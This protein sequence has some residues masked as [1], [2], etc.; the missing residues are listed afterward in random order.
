MKR[1][2]AWAA[3]FAFS[4][5]VSIGAAPLPIKG[6]DTLELVT[7]DAIALCSLGTL[8][9]YVGGGSGTGQA[10]MVAGTQQVAPMSREL[11]GTACTASASQLLIGLDG[12]SI[13]TSNQFFG[14][15]I[16]QTVETDDNCS[17][18]I[19]GDNSLTVAGCT[20]ADGCNTP[21]TY[22]FTDWKDVMAMVYGG[23]NHT[24][25]VQ[26]INGARNPARINCASPVRQALVNNWNAVFRDSILDPQPCRATDCLRLKHAFRRGDQSGTTDTF[27]TLV[28]LVAIPPYTTTTANNLPIPDANAT[29]NPFCNAGDNKMNKGDAD[30]LDLD[31]IR[32]IVDSDM[33]ANGRLGFEQVAQGFQPPS[34][35]PVTQF[36]D[37]RVEPPVTVMADYSS[38]TEVNVLPDPGIANSTALQQAALLNRK[39]LGV[40]LPIEIPGNYTDERVAYYSTVPSQ[41]EPVICSPGKFAPS[42]A[43][44]QHSSTALCPN[45]RPQPC[46]L[47]VYLDPA[48]GAINF[49]C[50]TNSPVPVAAPLRDGR[51][52]NLLVVDTG[53][54]YVRDNYVNP[55]LPGLSVV[56]QNR[57]V[58]ALFRLHISQVTNL[59]APAPGI[60]C[61]KF[62]ST[63]QIG[64]LVAASPCS[65]GFAG[66]EAVDNA[67]NIAMQVDGI[68]ATSPNIE[69]LV[70]GS[71]NPIYPLARRLWFN[72]LNGFGSVSGDQ[73]SLV[74]CFQGLT[75]GVPLSD[76][77]VAIQRRNFVPV[78]AGV[79]RTKSCP[80]VFP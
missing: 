79:S 9:S 13:V 26:L 34:N 4:A 78:P 15:S 46:L 70:N 74:R 38:S 49:N 8:I 41:G 48:T 29:A 43:D 22:L 57:V 23:Q 45:G 62:S 63:E 50:L 47:P 28:G 76:I 14:D 39:G 30:Y 24:T 12:I 80:A 61:K 59:G 7:K 71:G 54:H 3:G 1:P 18:T 21:G 65:I 51:V 20:A 17:D 72:A 32:R 31:P 77:D 35:P 33:A 19:D 36:V 66:R 42:I 11:N 52:Y 6:S 44:A 68:K 69:N 67:L 75:P 73:L 56:R 16:D 5:S 53:G 10:A 27:V 55:N 60:N 64:C 37:D 40:V 2:I 25:A 58:N